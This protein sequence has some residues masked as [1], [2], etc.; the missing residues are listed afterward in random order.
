MQSEMKGFAVN[1]R[2]F[3]ICEFL[4]YKRL[5]KINMLSGEKNMAVIISLEAAKDLQYLIQQL[6]YERVVRLND[7]LSYGIAH[8]IDY[9]KLIDT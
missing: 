6:P 9:N 2:D 8:T 4:E 5:K 7:E 3:S 1:D